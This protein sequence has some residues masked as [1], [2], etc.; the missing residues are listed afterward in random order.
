MKPRPRPVL[1]EAMWQAS[2]PGRDYSRLARNPPH[3]WE[4]RRGHC[5]HEGRWSAT[6]AEALLSTLPAAFPASPPRLRAAN[7]YC[8]WVSARGLPGSSPSPAMGP[9]PRF[10]DR[11]KFS[12]PRSHFFAR[13]ALKGLR[14]S[15]CRSASH[16]IPAILRGLCCAMDERLLWGSLSAAY[17]RADRRLWPRAPCYTAKVI[18]RHAARPLRAHFH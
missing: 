12:A 17:G 14:M 7:G 11:R 18:W 15:E 6:A 8:P 10:G 5:R 9:M 1:P 13:E 2:G 16:R 4:A 3:C